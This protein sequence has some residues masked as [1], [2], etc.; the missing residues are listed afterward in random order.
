MFED[1]L[2][3]AGSKFTMHHSVTEPQAFLCAGIPLET[4][5]EVFLAE[6]LF[7]ME[8]QFLHHVRFP[9]DG[10]NVS[11]DFVFGQFFLWNGGRGDPYNGRIIL[12]IE[13]KRS[14]SNRGKY[15]A[16]Y[17]RLATVHN[18]P[19][20]ILTRDEIIKWRTRGRLPIT[21]CTLEAYQK[22]SK[23]S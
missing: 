2:E 6:L 17:K 21:P 1:G 19:V 9:V 16:V 13:A 18:V 23:A 20:L 11:P 22:Y 5:E 7:I 15:Q 8:V 14:D 3:L 4:E 12:G 10:R